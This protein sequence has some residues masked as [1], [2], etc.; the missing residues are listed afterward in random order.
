MEKM[1]AS[2]AFDENAN[3]C[4]HNGRQ[5]RGSLPKVAINILLKIKILMQP[6]FKYIS[7]NPYDQYLHIRI[8][9]SLNPYLMINTFTRIWKMKSDFTAISI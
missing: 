9:I 1:E 7:L 4:I 8:Y 5:F 6:R 2:Y 3:E